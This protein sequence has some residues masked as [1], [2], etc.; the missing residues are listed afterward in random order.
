MEN[1]GLKVSTANENPHNIGRQ[2]TGLIF[3][4]FFFTIGMRDWL[5]VAMALLLGGLTFA[6][7]WTAGIYKDADSKSFLNISPMGWGIVVPML[8]IAG[9]PAYAY[10]RNKLK[11]KEGHIVLFGSVLLI[12]SYGFLSMFWAI[13]TLIA[14]SLVA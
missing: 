7:A 6:D 4:I 8:L 13:W 1:E 11:T 12:G 3:W 5:V 10:G 9:L 2:V 14:D